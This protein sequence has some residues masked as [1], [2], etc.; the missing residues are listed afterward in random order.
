[1]AYDRYARGGDNPWRLDIDQLDMPK[2]QPERRRPRQPPKSETPA[3]APAA[4]PASVPTAA[5]VSPP[6]GPPPLD[7]DRMVREAPP[8]MP[9]LPPVPD[10]GPHPYIAQNPYRGRFGVGAIRPDPVPEPVPPTFAPTGT[11]PPMTALDGPPP[12]APPPY[13]N[14][15]RQRGRAL[16]RTPASGEAPSSDFMT[17]VRSLFSGIDPTGGASGR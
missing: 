2:A 8:E 14:P 7:P 17:W 13:F 10:V 5:P 4:A 6:R 9:E 12:P 1:M 3:A 16:P 15:I 11:M